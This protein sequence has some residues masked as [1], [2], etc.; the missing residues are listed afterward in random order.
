MTYKW[1]KKLLMVDNCLFDG[2]ARL[3]EYYAA[4][5]QHAP[6]PAAMCESIM[7]EINETRLHLRTLYNEC[8]ERDDEQFYNLDDLDDILADIRKKAG[9]KEQ[10]CRAFGQNLEHSQVRYSK[11]LERRAKRWQR[12][13]LSGN[14][15]PKASQSAKPSENTGKSA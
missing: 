11:L 4:L 13:S 15:T 10:L 8:W 12:L 5:I 3:L 6:I 1:S 7:L 14:H 9:I 2:I